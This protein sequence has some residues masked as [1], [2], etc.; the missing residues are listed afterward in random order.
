[1]LQNTEKYLVLIDS[2]WKVTFLS[3]SSAGEFTLSATVAKLSFCFSL[4]FQLLNSN[5]ETNPAT[6]TLSLGE[7]EKQSWKYNH[8]SNA[9]L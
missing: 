7:K 3:I 2:G 9:G 6:K 1:M 4:F 5:W 8:L